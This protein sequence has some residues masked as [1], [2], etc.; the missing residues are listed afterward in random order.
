MVML[1]GVFVAPLAQN[2]PSVSASHIH[3]SPAPEDRLSTPKL[4]PRPWNKTL[5]YRGMEA[6]VQAVNWKKETY[7]V[8]VLTKVRRAQITYV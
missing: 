1:R 4:N 2:P 8:L 5:N 6:K 7:A 3:M